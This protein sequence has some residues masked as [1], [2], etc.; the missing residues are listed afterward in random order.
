MNN[1]WQIVVLFLLAATLSACLAPPEAAPQTP[2][3]LTAKAISPGVGSSNVPIDSLIQVNL[4]RPADAPA[5]EQVTFSVSDGSATVSGTTSNSGGDVYTF[6]PAVPLAY[7]TGYQVSFSAWVPDRNI[8]VK[9]GWNFKTTF[10]TL[11]FGSNQADYSFDMIIGAASTIWVVGKTAGNMPATASFGNQ[12]GF[13]SRFDGSSLMHTPI[14]TNQMD[15]ATVLGLHA[16]GKVTVAGQ[17]SGDYAGPTGGSDDLFLVQYD[18]LGAELWRKQIGN[19]AN[20]SVT[21]MAID[22]ANNIVMTG[23]TDGPIDIATS[24]LGLTDSWVGKLDALGNPSWFA[25]L[26]VAG[27]NTQANSIATDPN[28]GDIYIAGDTDG[29]LDAT[30]AAAGLDIFVAKYNPTGALL[31]LKQIGSSGDESVSSI[32][33]DDLGNILISGHS[34]ADLDG[35]GANV[36]AGNLDIF[37]AK[38]SAAGNMLWLRQMGSIDEDQSYDMALA[39]SGDIYL[40][41]YSRGDL[42][43]PTAGGSD[44]VLV[45]LDAAGNPLWKRQFGSPQNDEARNVAI[46]S[47]G[48]IVLSGITEDQLDGNLSQGNSDVFI[49]RYSATG[50]R[51]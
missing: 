6:T 42:A 34:N 35:T 46:D 12:D 45:K 43:S 15:M 48:D 17:T 31:W 2:Q 10:S 9:C 38:L 11:Q 18:V 21:G 20:E 13:L 41:G 30:G 16:S 33:V 5:L 3:R 51:R 14:G 44:I 28:S 4:N 23:R 50:N 8:W 25:Q 26:G 37:A 36:H 49:V 29:I 7:A 40:C 39:A 24:L 32:A 27:A 19:T 1:P 47:N 22:L